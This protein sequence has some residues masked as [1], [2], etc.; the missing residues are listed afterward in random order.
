[1]LNKVL[2]KVLEGLKLGGDL[3]E[4]QPGFVTQPTTLSCRVGLGNFYLGDTSHQESNFGEVKAAFSCH[5]FIHDLEA[6]Q[7]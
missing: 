7:K 2:V 4:R 3:K 1:M 5:H 6:E